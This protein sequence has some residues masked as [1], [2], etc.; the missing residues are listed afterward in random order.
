MV[1]YSRMLDALMA[2]I[3]PRDHAE[4]EIIYRLAAS[5]WDK[6]QTGE[7]NVQHEVPPACT[8]TLAVA[9]AY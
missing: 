8:G 1:D 3:G 4:K 2:K 5:Q 9:R 6:F 7:V